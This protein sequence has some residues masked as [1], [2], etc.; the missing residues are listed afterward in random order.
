MDRLAK[1]DIACY[2]RGW[3][4]DAVLCSGTPGALAESR[5]ILAPRPALP[6]EGSAGNGQYNTVRGTALPCLAQL[7][8]RDLRLGRKPDLI[9]HAG[10]LPSYFFYDA[11]LR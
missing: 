3:R 1:P 5:T 9:G 11:A 2:A 10:L 6:F 8:D 7:R 4:I